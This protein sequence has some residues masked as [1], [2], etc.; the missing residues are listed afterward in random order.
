MKGL[1]APDLAEKGGLKGGAPQRFDQRLF[2]QLLAYGDCGDA[3]PLA[4][5]LADAAVTGVLY[6][7]L[8]DPRGAAVLALSRDPNFFVDTLRPI[9]ACDPFVRLTPRPEFT[10]FGRTYALGY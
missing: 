4:Q 6:E 1:E 10:M 3:R 5:A 9:L 8:N 7:D 2:M